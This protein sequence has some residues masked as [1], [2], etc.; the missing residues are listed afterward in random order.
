VEKNA[1]DSAPGN[2]AMRID[3]LTP[4]PMMCGGILGSS[5]LRRAQDAGHVEINPRNLRD[6]TTDRHHTTDDTP[7]GGGPGMVMKIEPIAAALKA[8]RT[9]NAKIIL[10]SPQGR[11]FNQKK[12]IDLAKEQHLIFVCGHYEGI[13]QRVADHLVDEEISIGDYVLTNGVIAALVV[14]DAL[15]RLLPGVLGDENSAAQDSFFEGL[16]DT[17]HYTKPPDFQGWKVPDVL[18]S[19]N[20]GAISQWRQQQA[21][22]RTQH[23]R[24]DL[25][26]PQETSEQ[27]NIPPC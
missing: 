11:T 9:P 5:I 1:G 14:I 12:A 10:L 16:L 23:L 24:P 22:D 26:Q 2:D 4:F 19:G 13:D 27:N 21:L 3:V 8:L 25:L 20:H 6:W 17:P 7:Y 18:L 15:V